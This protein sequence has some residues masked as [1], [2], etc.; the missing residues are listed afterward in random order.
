[1]QFRTDVEIISAT[2]GETKG[3]EQSRGI[4]SS[5][6]VTPAGSE[7]GRESSSAGVQ[8]PLPE[9]T[10]NC[11]SL[12]MSCQRQGPQS[13][14]TELQICGS[15]DAL[16][17]CEPEKGVEKVLDEVSRGSSDVFP[18]A[19]HPLASD[20]YCAGP[21]LGSCNI[22]DAGHTPFMGQT[23]GEATPQDAEPDASSTK[24]LL[25]W[26]LGNVF[27]A[28]LQ[29]MKQ[30]QPSTRETCCKNEDFITPENG[31]TIGDGTALCHPTVEHPLSSHHQGTQDSMSPSV[32]PEAMPPAMPRPS[33]D[34]PLEE[35]GQS[36][37]MLAENVFQPMSS[38]LQSPSWVV[39]NPSNNGQV[40]SQPSLEDVRLPTTYLPSHK[41]MDRALPDQ[42]FAGFSCS[43]PGRRL[44]QNND[45]PPLCQHDSLDGFE[46]TERQFMS[47]SPVASLTCAEQERVD[48]S[49]TFQD[50]TD[51]MVQLQPTPS[52]S[53]R[54]SYSLAAS[55]EGLL[56][57]PVWRPSSSSFGALHP[58]ALLPHTSPSLVFTGSQHST[59]NTSQPTCISASQCISASI[60]RAVPSRQTMPAQVQFGFDQIN[61]SS[62]PQTGRRHM[63]SS[64]SSRSGH[65]SERSGRGR[66]SRLKGRSGRS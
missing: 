55:A 44:T 12:T 21:G 35:N 66:S 31:R 15:Q 48:E 43:T 8:L 34:Y 57:C 19:E 37:F 45:C 51:T 2:S 42:P 29:V 17:S 7:T 65:M 16:Q 10:G 3:N 5:T 13:T 25:A 61:S 54:H 36:S 22:K 9:G 46:P 62:R 14:A 49:F 47:S 52:I 30:D 50:R 18:R 33:F 6:I 56:P 4:E 24:D 38:S 11:C 23:A 40:L 1:M 64:T 58:V 39:S 20:V 26:M 60:P 28:T 53:N 41:Q 32:C 59:G 63:S 27:S